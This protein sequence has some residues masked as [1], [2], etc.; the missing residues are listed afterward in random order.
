MAWQIDD[1][2]MKCAFALMYCGDYAKTEDG[3]SDEFIYIAYNMYWEP[4][5]FAMP[6]LP[7]G[8]NWIFAANTAETDSFHPES[9]KEIPEFSEDKC[10][11]VP[12]RS[13]IIL[14]SRSQPAEPKMKEGKPAE[15]KT[16]EPK[17]AE[18]KTAEPEP[19]ET[20]PAEPHEKGSVPDKKK[21]SKS[22][23]IKKK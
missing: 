5:A 6:D 18:A 14:T 11:I 22:G 9:W 10:V 3:A 16:A 8:M 20:K 13:V 1:Y 4:Q 2:E 15:A 7:E 19:A 12:A 23:Q 17:P 21:D